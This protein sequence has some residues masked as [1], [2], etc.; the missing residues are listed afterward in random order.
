LS[1]ELRLTCGAASSPLPVRWRN[2]AIS[3]GPNRRMSAALSTF[4]RPSQT[5]TCP[6]VFPSMKDLCFYS[7]AASQRRWVNNRNRK[8]S[9]MICVESEQ[10]CDPVGLHGRDKPCVVRSDSRDSKRSDQIVPA[11]K[12][13]FAIAQ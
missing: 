3:F 1:G 2:D 10:A 5:G 11:R 9:E 13:L 4:I 7:R 6:G 8:S 12:Q